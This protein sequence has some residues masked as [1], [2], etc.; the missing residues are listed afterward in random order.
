MIETT[1]QHMGEGAKNLLSLVTKQQWARSVVEKVVQSTAALGLVAYVSTYLGNTTYIDNII[2]IIC[3]IG[4]FKESALCGSIS[5]IAFIRL[6]RCIDSADRLHYSFTQ[7]SP[8]MGLSLT[9]AFSLH[10]P[11]LWFMTTVR[12]DGGA[13]TSAG[14]ATIP[15]C[16]HEPYV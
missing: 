15:D 11:S 12:G 3:T 10:V 5:P 4:C 13:L 8:I 9:K 7:L 16:H 14:G 1:G 2:S 6:Y